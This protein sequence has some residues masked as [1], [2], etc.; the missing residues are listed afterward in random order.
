MENVP[1]EA[2]EGGEIRYR[3][4]RILSQEVFPSLSSV[5]VFIIT[6]NYISI[7]TR[8]RPD[9]DLIVFSIM[10]T[11]IWLIFINPIL[12]MEWGVPDDLGYKWNETWG[13]QIQFITRTLIIF[14]AT[15]I[16]NVFGQEFE[17]FGFTILESIFFLWIIVLQYYGFQGFIIQLVETV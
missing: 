16:V 2:V 5:I 14:T 15:L 12:M 13:K 11:I 8:W 4:N 3:D 6:S 17:A 10:L 9:Y 7:I 1:V